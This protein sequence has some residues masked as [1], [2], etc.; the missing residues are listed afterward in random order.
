[1]G[2]HTLLL[3]VVFTVALTKSSSWSK[4]CTKPMADAGLGEFF[5][6]A[7]AHRMH[8][9]TLEDLRY[10]FTEDAPV[11]NG[12]PT[13]NLDFTPNL[14]RI[15]PNA[16]KSGYDM[17]FTTI[18]L[19]HTD[20]VLSKMNNKDWGLKY[21]SV[22]EKLVHAHHMSELWERSKKYY[23]NFVE[24]PPTEEVCSCLRDIK[25]N[26]VLGELKLLALKFKF[27]ELFSGYPKYGK[28]KRVKVD[29]I[30]YTF[31]YKALAQMTRKENKGWCKKLNNFDFKGDEK[32]VVERAVKELGDG[33]QD[34]IDQ[35]TDEKA[36]K[37]W[38]E[39]FKKMDE[40]DNFQFGMFIYCMLNK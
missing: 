14:D 38:K 25:E 20:Q 35:L 3:F 36:W 19:R 11:E 13:V 2:K 39:G 34:L 22:L 10:Y 5:G 17:N 24:S 33:D 6:K 31:S 15:L 32:D 37:A 8:S 27:P 30:S 7:V 9:L 12:I 40:N 1:M 23:E 28:G 16:P 29:R 18:A 21:Y 4:T 26:C